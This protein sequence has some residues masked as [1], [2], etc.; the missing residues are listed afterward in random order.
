LRRWSF[1]ATIVVMIITNALT[2][3]LDELLAITASLVATALLVGIARWDGLSFADL[4]L[5]GRAETL[6]GVR[7]GAVIFGVVG[8]FYVVLLMSPARELLQDDRL[9]ETA[10]SALVQ[11]FIIIPLKTVLWEE[12]AFR[13]VLWALIKRDHGWRIATIVS[14]V[15]F[16]LWHVLPATTF[17]ESNAAATSTLGAGGLATTVIVI[18]TVLFTGL[19]GI[20][21]CELRRRSGSLIAPL[22][23]HWSTNGLGT[24]ASLLA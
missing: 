19:A 22:A 11:A 20:V 5:G 15:L 9:P 2:R 17:A 23:A 8:A 16:G 21:L 14:S 24:L 18:V 12:V 4:G 13:G 3:E 1:W 6:R 10:S 7:W